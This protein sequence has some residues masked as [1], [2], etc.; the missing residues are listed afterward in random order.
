MKRSLLK[1]FIVMTI[2]CSFELT[3]S[4]DGGGDG[5]SGGESEECVVVNFPD[6]NLEAVIRATIGKGSG[7]IC[8]SDCKKIKVLDSKGLI[9]EADFYG[10]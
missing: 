10:R 8:E 3:V 7:D 5:G 9:R 4:C 6:P 1:L 2:L